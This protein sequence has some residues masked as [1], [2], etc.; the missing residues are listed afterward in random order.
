MDISV[1]DNGV[2]VFGPFRLDPVRRALL[3]D[4]DPLTLPPRLFD[5]LL[6]LVENAGRVVGN[7]LPVIRKKVLT[8]FLS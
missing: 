4:G 2:Y 7:R 6:Y 5:T 3:R 8:K 1:R